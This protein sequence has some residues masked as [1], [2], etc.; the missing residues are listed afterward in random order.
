[1]SSVNTVRVVDPEV[2]LHAS[3]AEVA[4]VWVIK[5]RRKREM[6]DMLQGVRNI[7]HK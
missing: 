7:A 3:G 1:M 4:W 6:I 5:Q 2:A